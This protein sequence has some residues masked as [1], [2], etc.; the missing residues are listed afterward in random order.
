MNLL[1]KTTI[2]NLLLALVAFVIGGIQ[3]YHTFKYE[4]KRETDFSLIESFQPLV[5][6][7]E[8]GVP[9]AEL[10]SWMLYITTI[11]RIDTPDMQLVFSDTLAFHPVLKRQE[12][13]RMLTTSR[14]INGVNYRFKV[15]NVF[16]EESDIG[17]IVKNVLK[18]LFI[19]LGVILIIFSLLISKFLL[20]PF[21]ETM[22]KIKSFNLQSGEVPELPKTTTT[23]FR[24]LNVFLKEML[25]KNR[26]DYLTLKE[27]SENA[28]HEMQTPL[29]VAG[30]KLEL[31]VESNALDLAQLQLVQETQHSLSQLSKLGEAL[32]LLTKIENQEFA[33]HTKYNF[34]EIL[35]VDVSN[36][37]ELAAMKGLKFQK[38]ILPVVQLQ[39]DPSLGHILIN[40]LLKN[41]I[42]HNV[43]DGWVKV[44]LDHQSLRIF[45]SGPP[46]PVPTEQLFERFQKSNQTS[47]SLGLGLAIVKKICQ[48]NGL[49]IVYNYQ[50]GVHE[51]VITLAG[52]S[53]AR[54]TSK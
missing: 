44:S 50:E 33:P 37:E 31:L 47:K 54:S 32:L 8:A 30:G 25:E 7:M 17:R 13:L 46:P 52:A 3:V 2:F 18:D 40:N 29:A 5:S 27:F 39:L 53:K 49:P 15:M 16:I 12:P 45:N 1:A 42:R 48:V 28:S 38:N 34:S 36:F 21:K 10:Q 19:V 11:N 26:K 24:Q 51:V 4:V 43:K 20:R 23:E 41:A 14:N 22:Q 35:Q 6:A 9:A